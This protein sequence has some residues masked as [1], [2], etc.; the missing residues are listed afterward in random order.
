MNGVFAG[1]LQKILGSI[2]GIED[3]E[4]LGGQGLALGQLFLRGLLAEQSPAGIR[5]CST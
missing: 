1:A 2:E 4:P 5:K 3:P